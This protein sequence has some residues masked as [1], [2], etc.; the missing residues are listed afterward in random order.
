[1]AA[2]RRAI[3]SAYFV[4]TACA[5]MGLG[6]LGWSVQIANWVVRQR[7]SRSEYD[8]WYLSFS[9][10]GAGVA[11]FGMSVVLVTLHAHLRTAGA[12]ALSTSHAFEP[13]LARAPR[14]ELSHSPP[15]AAPAPA[16]PPPDSS[17]SR[18]S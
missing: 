2:P 15:T 4:G 5:V 8:R 3:V 1:M 6:V 18:P 14:D 10:V 13:L 17:A 7:W 11:L 12:D 16:P 9:A